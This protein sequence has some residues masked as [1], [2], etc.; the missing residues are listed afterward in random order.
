MFHGPSPPVEAESEQQPVSK[1][2]SEDLSSQIDP[3]MALASDATST[4]NVTMSDAE[5]NPNSRPPND[6]DGKD[7]LVKII[8]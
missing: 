6:M 2:T 7:A 3:P 8:F 4:P 5:N 1:V